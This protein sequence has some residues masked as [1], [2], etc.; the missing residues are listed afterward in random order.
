MQYL[1]KSRVLVNLQCPRKLWLQAHRPDLAGQ[2]SGSP[3]RLEAGIRL[4][5]IARSLEPGGIL[6]AAED[7]ARALRE[8]AAHHARGTGAIFEATYQK[9]GVLVRADLM[10]HE[11]GAWRM[12]EVKSAAS[13]KEYHLVDAAVQAWVVRQSGIPLSAVEI[14]HVDTGFV[15]PGEG[16]YQGL[17]SHVDV[18]AEVSDLEDLVPEWI[19]AA[20]ETLAGEDPETPPGDQCT[21]PFECPYLAFCTPEDPDS[22]PLELLPRSSKLLPR[23]R[24]EGYR[25]LREVP[26]ERLDKEL[27]RRIVEATRSGRP[28]VDPAVRYRLAALPPPYHYLDFETIQFVVPVWAGTR[29][30]EQIPF[31]WSCHIEDESGVQH[32]AFLAD[33]MGDPR[34]DF[35]RTLLDA[36]GS[37]GTIFV[38]N[39]SFERACMLRLAEAFPVLAPALRAATERIVDLL[40][41]ARDHYYHPE[42]RGSWSIKAVLPTIAPHLSYADLQVADGGTAQE[43]FAEF[44]DEATSPERRAELREAL[45]RYCE[46]D[47]WGMVEVVRY[48]RGA[49]DKWELLSKSAID[50]SVP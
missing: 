48:L 12:T 21:D 38:Y 17:L 27:H 22:F 26:P 13:V 30:Y 29:P 49:G 34:R 6:I 25:D 42:M 45:L 4:G 14:A 33:A 44:L 16:R 39:A 50:P 7:L 40:P 8:T 37:S 20:R 47:T 31:Q 9:D 1:S 2:S 32:R 10:R 5:E 18:T 15:Y 24:E 46:R 41:I 36:L 35:A 3:F 28:W 19:N 11:A 43:A 23:L